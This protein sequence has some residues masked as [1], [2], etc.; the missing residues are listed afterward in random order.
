MENNELRE[1]IQSTGAAMYQE[2]YSHG[3]AAAYDQ[4]GGRTHY[5]DPETLRFFGARILA[6]QSACN[7]LLYWIVESLGKDGRDG[8]R[9][10]RFVVFDVWGEVIERAPL[11]EMFSTSD[12]ARAAFYDWLGAFDL[13]DHYTDR[14]RQELDRTTRQA[15]RLADALGKVA[16]TA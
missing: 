1:I 15:A 13:A 3:A 10:F 12:K 4:L 2:R 7:G 11:A 9:G 14:L 6:A 5:A 16:V 8:K